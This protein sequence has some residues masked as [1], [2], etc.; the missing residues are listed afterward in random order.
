M[1]DT[2]D[3]PL[4]FG[5]LFVGAMA[6]ALALGGEFTFRPPLCLLALEDVAQV[7]LARALGLRGWAVRGA[8]ERAC[9]PASLRG[10]QRLRRRRALGRVCARRRHRRAVSCCGFGCRV[11]LNGTHAL[12]SLLRRPCQATRS[13]ARS[14]VALLAPMSNWR[15]R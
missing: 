1:F 7:A 8:H 5:I 13:A 11:P 3:G 4:V 14:R 10:R 12:S 6:G 2:G 15:S 9:E